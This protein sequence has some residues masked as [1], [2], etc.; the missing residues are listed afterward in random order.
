MNNILKYAAVLALSLFA[1]TF[2]M[3]AQ[4][5]DY[6]TMQTAMAEFL[7]KGFYTIKV[8]YVIPAGARE[9]KLKQNFT[10]V[11]E[12]SHV[13]VRLP[14]HGQ[15]HSPSYTSVD[16]DFDADISDN[17]FK[18]ILK[19]KKSRTEI[20]FSTDY[21]TDSYT[22]RITIYPNGEA[23]I[24]LTSTYKSPINYRGKVLVKTIYE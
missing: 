6:E 12:D 18:S 11:L 4:T 15:S 8:D 21:E 16:L 17:N 5:S 2:Q 3:S 19:G 13:Y 20:N 7:E 14:H 10:V 23:R 22:F 1:A 9:V 24:Y